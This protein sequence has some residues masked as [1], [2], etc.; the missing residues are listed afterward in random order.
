MIDNLILSF[1]TNLN[2][3]IPALPFFDDLKD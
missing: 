3:G 1:A 2:N